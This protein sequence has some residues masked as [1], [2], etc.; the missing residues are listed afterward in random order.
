MVPGLSLTIIAAYFGLLY[1]IAWY[2]G[3]NAT[4]ETFFTGQRNSPWY[5]VAFGMIGASLSGV[6]FISVPGAV[7]TSNWSYFQVVLGYIVGYAVIG[8]V[9]LPLYY[10][11]N[12]VSIYGYLGRRFGQVSYRT[13]SLF[14][15][16]S[17][18][19]GSSLRLYLAVLV[20]HLALFGPLGVPI[21]VTIVSSIAL[22]YLYTFKGGIRTVVWTDTFQTFALLTAAVIVIVIISREMHLGLGE[23]LAQVK[24]SPMSQIFVWDWAPGGN[25]FKQ[26]ISGAFIALAMTGLDQDMM[27]KNLTCRNLPDAQRNMFWFTITLVFVNLM[28]LIL[29]VLLYQY[30]LKMEY[31]QEVYEQ[32]CALRILNPA[33][34]LME[35][36][37]TDQLFPRLAL[38]LMGPAVA[39][40]FLL[41]VIAAAYS[42]ADSTLT[43]LTTSFCYDILG[44]EAQTDSP[45][46][47]RTR[48]RVHLGFAALMALFILFFHS[49]NNQA[50]I[51]AVFTFA[52]Y[53]YGP[54]L[55]LFAFGLLTRRTF[56]DKW[57]AAICIAAPFLT[58][59]I[60]YLSKAAGFDLGFIILLVNGGVTF[61]GLWAI[62]RKSTAAPL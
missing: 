48:I 52:G 47:K 55:G 21:W 53:T 31:V 18:M 6:T 44:F 32:G 56:E 49:L 3:R 8:L 36:A 30:G 7:G 57:A 40:T 43:A 38:N 20:L 62:S 59:G 61:L 25:F 22:I 23:M 42:S 58:Y 9:L 28:F 12:L 54:L 5:V 50:V 51:W 24:Q 2:T 37:G 10:R 19:L 29:G 45:A 35:C 26:F 15:I 39:I 60:Q 17:R 16:L 33:T 1:I 11:L 34:G 41:G 27:Q 14:F 4:E 13:G 46:K